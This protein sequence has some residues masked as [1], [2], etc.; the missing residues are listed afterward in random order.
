VSAV[1]LGGDV[2]PQGHGQGLGM[3]GAGARLGQQSI[4]AALVWKESNLV[5]F[6]FS[7]TKGG[8]AK[9]DCCSARLITGG[10]ERRGSRYRQGTHQGIGPLHDLV[11]W[12]GINYTG[13]QITQWDFKNKGTQTRPA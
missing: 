1:F 12:Y 4:T 10:G 13:T 3:V 2:T 5:L 11:T 9:D 7:N 8:D 6:G